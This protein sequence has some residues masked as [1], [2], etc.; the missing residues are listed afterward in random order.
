MSLTLSDA[1]HLLGNLLGEVLA[2]RES[3]ALLEA[4]ER[5]RALAKARRAGNTAAAA[6]LARD[7]ESLPPATAR[8]I[9]SAF[10]LYF[11]LVNLAEEVH[12]I[13]ELRRRAREQAP[14]PISESIGETVAAL[15]RSGVTRDQMAALLRDLSV[16]LVLTAH[17]TEAK[18]RSV[19]SKLQRISSTLSELHRDDLVPQ[20]QAAAVVALRA[21]ITALW[22]TD[23]ARTARPEVTD[24][25]RTG[26]YFVEHTFWEVLPRVHAG[27]AAAV[28]EHYPGLTVPRRW[29]GLGSW[30]G[31]DRDGNPYVT[32]DVTAETLRLH[33]GL[34]V[35]QHRRALQDLA[36]RFSVSDRRLPL[37]AGL[38]TWL[39]GRRPLP[40]RA[41]YLERRY[42]DEPY[43]IVL[44]LLAADLGA[45]SA[46]DMTARLLETRPHRA[47]AHVDAL[48]GPLDLLAAAVP[49][50]LA[51]DRLRTVRTQIDL[52]G[53]HAARLDLRED[54]GRLAGTLDQLRH[55]WGVSA[56]GLETAGPERA[57]ALE[58]LLAAAPPPAAPEPDGLDDAARETWALFQLLARARSVY[59]SELFGPFVI[60]MARSAADVLTVLVLAR[61]AGGADGLPVAPLFE[62][63]DDLDQA[64][65]VLAELF[66]LEAY[67]TH[68]ASCG[69]EQ[70]IMIG[71]SDSNKDGGYLA[72]N[73]A[74]YRAQERIA[75]VCREHGVRLTLFHGRGGS[76][77]RGGGPAGR[78]IRAQ[79]P[80][81]VGGRFRVT[82]QGEVLASRYA[83][84]DLAYRHLEQVVSAVLLASAPRSA[85]EVPALWRAEMDSL[86][87]RARTAY[88][89]LVHGTPGFV[90]YWR[91]ATPIDEIARLRI[92]SRPPS[93]RGRAL[94]VADVRAIPW[95]FSWMQSRFNLPGWYGLGTALAAGALGDLRAMY[96]QW[97][98]LHALLDNAEMSLLKADMEIAALYSDL[99]PDRSLAGR[100]FATIRA[101]YDRTHEAILAITG[102]PALMAGDP[103]IQRSV[104]LRNP[105]V[106]PLN[107]LQVEMLRRLRALPDADGAGAEPFREVLFLT[108]NGIAAGLRNTG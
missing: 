98:F 30:I 67:R 45:A 81:T 28:A 60:S 16:E 70:T 26:L 11:D 69:G 103:V 23:R 72:S 5:I 18:R 85:P 46:E 92:G 77:A 66:A 29:L 61:W 34:A 43:R 68:L 37:P 44:A 56:D 95:V 86:A 96:Q 3:P 35:S 42:G 100:V 15:R 62:T 41:A 50:P 19:L 64:P 49:A 59:G 25:V 71:Y 63:L 91:G 40:E 8:A 22:L 80:G 36:R 39:A 84:P 48:A 99:V 76:V 97:P 89:E 65:A 108:I 106:D 82:E 88:R 1:I 47:H 27:L 57:R 87:Q 101:E 6:T 14:E 74:L 51:E 33:R 102:H 105:Y 7:V 93:R 2:A 54:A 79:P 104:H 32:A 107:Y 20:E 94:A 83:A 9:A 52:F 21:E 38:S 55:V 24:E 17:P 13:Q 12:R 90:D 4:E 58:A 73:W 75:R 78:A 10:T 31:G 53:L